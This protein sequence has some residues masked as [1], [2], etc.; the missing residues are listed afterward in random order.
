VGDLVARVRQSLEAGFASVWVEGEVSNLRVPASGH[1]YFTLSD[2]R[3]QLRAVCFRTVARLLRVELKDGARVLAR[4]RLTLYEA[5]GDVQLVVEDVESLGEGLARLELEALK[6]RLA[7]EGLFAPERKRP[8]PL[9]PRAVGVVTSPTGAALR[10]VLHVLRRRAPGVSVYLAPAAVQGEGAAAELRA[11]LTLA[12]SQPD[13]EVIVLG[14]GGGSAEDLS[15]FNDETLV[16]AVA[17][18]PVPV[19]AAVGHEIDVTLVDFAADLRAPTPSAAAELAVREW[20]RWGE[21]VRSAGE[22]LNSA[23][24]RWLDRWRREVERLDPRF[25]SPAARVARLR[26]A[27]D[28]GAEALEA[29]LARRMLRI[30]ARVAAAETRL[31]RLAPER[32]LGAVREQLGRLEERLQAWPDGALALRRRDVR[33]REGELRALSP[34]AVLGRGYALVRHPTAG[35]VRDAASCRVGEILEVRL[36]QGE[37]DCRVTGVRAEERGPG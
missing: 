24:L 1:A 16:R 5:R 37:L 4:G 3:A 28:R 19:I 17:A 23:F 20:A 7:A 11:A 2:E 18:C 6:R 21:Q 35:L 15:A 8:L 34:L 14:R 33:Q 13:V 31:A 22:R 32:R 27:L 12:A 10:D 26:I 30:R 25:R 9:L 36:S 29:A